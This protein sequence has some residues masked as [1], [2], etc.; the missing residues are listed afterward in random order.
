MSKENL[1]LAQ[2]GVESLDA[3]WSMLDE[4]V[5]WDLRAWPIPDLDA[6]TKG[7]EAVIKASRHYWGTWDEYNVEAEEILDADPNVVVIIHEHGRGKS[8]GAPF[9]QTHPQVWTFRDGRIIRWASFSSR[10][11]ALEAAGLSA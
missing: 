3:F 5:V 9:A 8:S 2:R 10:A 6:V 4:E 7:R 11:E 1:E